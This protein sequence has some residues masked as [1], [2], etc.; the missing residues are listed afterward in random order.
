VS[1]PDGLSIKFSTLGKHTAP[2]KYEKVVNCLL[3]HYR[4]LQTNM[5]DSMLLKR[6]Q[7]LY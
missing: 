3:K 2:I 1:N 4:C 7:H 5:A 6:K